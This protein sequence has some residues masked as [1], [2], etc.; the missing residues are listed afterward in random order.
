[1][2][3]IPPTLQAQL[4]TARRLMWCMTCDKFDGEVFS[5]RKK[6]SQGIG[7]VKVFL[8]PLFSVSVL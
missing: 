1:M 5:R 2:L 7:L 3:S 4:L 8:F 6:T